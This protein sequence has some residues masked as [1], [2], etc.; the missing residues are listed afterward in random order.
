MTIAAGIG[1]TISTIIIGVM[2]YRARGGPPSLPRSSLEFIGGSLADKHTGMMQ[3]QALEKL[4]A[5]IDELVVK[6][7][8][9][10]VQSSD[11]NELKDAIHKLTSELDKIIWKLDHMN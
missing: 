3:V 8:R 4:S 7:E 2:K 5:S 10:G 6:L 9:S 1:L 11:M